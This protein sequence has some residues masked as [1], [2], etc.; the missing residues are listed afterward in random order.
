LEW[1]WT[2]RDITGH[3]GDDPLQR[4]MRVLRAEERRNIITTVTTIT[5][6]VMIVM[7]VTV[8]LYCYGRREGIQSSCTPIY[9]AK[10]CQKD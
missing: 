8:G 4:D 3:A 5:P 10:F 7:M 6:P 1:K 2:N 9:L